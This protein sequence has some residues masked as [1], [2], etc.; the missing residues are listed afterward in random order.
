MPDGV[1]C[2]TGRRGRGPHR[3]SLRQLPGI[4]NNS[5]ADTDGDG[6]GTPVTA[7]P[8]IVN[9]RAPAEIEQLRAFK[10]GTTASFGWIGDGVGGPGVLVKRATDAF[11]VSRGLLSTLRSTGSYGPCFLQGLK[12]G[13]DDASIPPV[14]DGYFYLAQ[15]QSYDCGLG[16]LGF[17]SNEV[18]RLNS[19]AL[20]CAGQTYTDY[21][22]LG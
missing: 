12:R 22:R 1:E 15:A 18:Q 2:E 6:Q 19:D 11:T 17:G 10:S 21:V 4:A 8:S 20:A 3:R 9:D 14:G 5:Q 7:S 16:S 13:V